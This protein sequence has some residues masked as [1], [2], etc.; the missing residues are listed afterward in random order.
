[1]WSSVLQ[2]NPHGR[3]CPLTSCMLPDWIHLCLGPAGFR[4]LELS[5]VPAVLC[6]FDFSTVLFSYYDAQLS[7]IHLSPVP[8]HLF[9]C[10][11]W[12]LREYID[13]TAA[14]GVQ[15]V[16]RKLQ[17]WNP[18]CCMSHV[19]LST[20][21]CMSWDDD[22]RRVPR[23]QYTR[24]QT[25]TLLI[26]KPSARECKI[27]LV[28]FIEQKECIRYLKHSNDNVLFY[29]STLLKDNNEDIFPKVSQYSF[30]V[31]LDLGTKITLS[32]IKIQTLSV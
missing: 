27:C 13:A 29:N 18:G 10:C 3:V 23:R 9:R 25:K 7:S 32:L 22:S 26:R 31:L 20:K 16:R 1:M 8:S 12:A 11:S 2:R 24:L 19:E 21:S 28:R 30:R 5:C 15:R 6:V 4:V 17:G 14:H